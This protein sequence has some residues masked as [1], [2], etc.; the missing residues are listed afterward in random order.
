MNAATM[1]AWRMQAEVDAKN[2]QRRIARVDARKYDTTP[3][4]LTG[5][6]I[7]R[8]DAR[9]GTRWIG[10][11]LVAAEAGDIG[12][13]VST[14]FDDSGLPTFDAYALPR[15]QAAMELRMFRKAGALIESRADFFY[16]EPK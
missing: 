11:D 13:Q 14:G 9:S 1:I 12:F 15:S 2:F 3:A 8:V 5:F 7:R 16:V 6:D 10:S 4:P